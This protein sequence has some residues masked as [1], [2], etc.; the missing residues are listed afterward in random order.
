MKDHKFGKS[1]YD[2]RSSLCGKDKPRKPKPSNGGAPDIHKVSR[3]MDGVRANLG[4][5]KRNSSHGY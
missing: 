3:D 5:M 4:N 1:G 2:R